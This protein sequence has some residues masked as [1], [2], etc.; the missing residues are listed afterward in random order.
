MK[1]SAVLEK[2]SKDIFNFEGNFILE[3]FQNNL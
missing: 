2:I 3:K 1:Q